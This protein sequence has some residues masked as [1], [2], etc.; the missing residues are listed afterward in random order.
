MNIIE[1]FMI[2]FYYN[3]SNIL[4][5]CNVHTTLCVIPTIVDKTTLDI[6][7]QV[8][9]NL[10]QR[11]NVDMLIE[12]RDKL[13]TIPMNGIVSCTF[14]RNV[15]ECI[16]SL[17]VILQSNKDRITALTEEN[18][19]LKSSKNAIKKS[20]EITIAKLTEENERLKSLGVNLI[21]SDHTI[22]DMS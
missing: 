15:I 5:L 17:V 10:K 18:E 16:D 19:I 3:K 14:G 8:V 7:R 9:D 13:E 4:M 11:G 6:F 12:I 20:S 22:M 1:H 2:Q 21:Y